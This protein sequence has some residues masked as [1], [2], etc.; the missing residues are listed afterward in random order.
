V[1]PVQNI[2][3]FQGTR[4]T[5]KLPTLAT[6]TGVV[7]DTAKLKERKKKPSLVRCNNTV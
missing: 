2:K 1:I 5:F 6:A 4:G 3:D 7:L